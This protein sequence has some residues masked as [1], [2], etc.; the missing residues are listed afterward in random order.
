MKIGFQIEHLDPARGGAE[1]Y[2]YQFATELLA[3][4]HEVHLFAIGI[5]LHAARRLS[6]TASCGG[7]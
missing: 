6:R 3:A 7:A 4:G 1:T 2:V 5:R